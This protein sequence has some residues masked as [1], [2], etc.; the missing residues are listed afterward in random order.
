MA[1]C[2]QSGEVVSK[3][4]YFG[5]L[6][7]KGELVTFRWIEIIYHNNAII[8]VTYKR[9]QSTTYADV[10][11]SIVWGGWKGFSINLLDD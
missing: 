7:Y 6:S 3:E 11:C 9:E 2:L 8:A 1:S 10:S 5:A 4:K